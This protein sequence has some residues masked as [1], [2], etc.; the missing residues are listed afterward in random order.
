L[1]MS[2]SSYRMRETKEWLELQQGQVVQ[3]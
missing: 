2:G 1:N 3:N